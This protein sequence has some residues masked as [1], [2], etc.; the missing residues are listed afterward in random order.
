MRVAKADLV[1]TAANLLSAYADWAALEVA[2]EAFC[3]E[4]NARPHRVTRRAPVE[5]LAVERH[6]LHRLPEHPWDR[7]VR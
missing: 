6:R 7:G 4:I 2:C 5:M 3:D 1:P